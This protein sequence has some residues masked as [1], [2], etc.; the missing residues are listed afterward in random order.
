M[1]S[2]SHPHHPLQIEESGESFTNGTWGGKRWFVSLIRRGE[3]ERT[4]ERKKEERKEKRDERR[5]GNRT[6]A[7]ARATVLKA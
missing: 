3:R 2:G 6:G 7:S 1:R 5:E 4:I